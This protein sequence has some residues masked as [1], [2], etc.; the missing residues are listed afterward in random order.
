MRT[1]RSL[2]AAVIG[3]GALLAAGAQP[4]QAAYPVT[5][6][7]T[8][9]YGNQGCA[10]IDVTWYNRS[11]A[12]SGWV[13]DTYAGDGWN[14]RVCVYAYV[15]ENGTGS[16]RTAPDPCRTVDGAGKSFGYTI[17]G[18]DISGGFRSVS[19][20]LKWVSTGG[21]VYTEDRRTRNRPPA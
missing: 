10:T 12:I 6:F 8:M 15:G 2:A 4:A 17:D 20:E 5:E 18:S 7:P 14:M 3:T 11:V 1:L 16:Y 9:C 13:S 19:A 21:N